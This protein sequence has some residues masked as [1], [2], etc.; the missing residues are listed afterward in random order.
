MALAPRA[1][2]AAAVATAA[3]GVTVTAGVPLYA[4]WYR[5][6]VQ[7]LADPMNLWMFAGLLGV[8]VGLS[9]AATGGHDVYR[10][11][12]KRKRF[13][14]LVEGGRKS[15]LVKHMAELEE[16]VRELPPRYRERLKAV[17]ERYGIR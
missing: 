11:H 12:S 10:N 16:L 2:Y 1:R 7:G 17:K 3:A 5:P 14:E 6:E 8:L 15:S 9:I 4:F 13:E